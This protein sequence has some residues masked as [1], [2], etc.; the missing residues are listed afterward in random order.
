MEEKGNKNTIEGTSFTKINFLWIPKE[1]AVD[2]I[3]NLSWAAEDLTLSLSL[4]FPVHE[5]INWTVLLF[6]GKNGPKSTL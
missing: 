5:M 3:G 6:K 2:K 1:I 4:T